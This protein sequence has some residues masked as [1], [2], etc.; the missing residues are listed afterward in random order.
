MVIRLAI[1]RVATCS[2]LQEAH[3]LL[4]PVRPLPEDLLLH[5]LSLLHSGSFFQLIAFSSFQRKSNLTW[6]SPTGAKWQQPGHSKQTSTALFLAKPT[7]YTTSKRNIQTLCCITAFPASVCVHS[8]EPHS[9]Q[10]SSRLSVLSPQVS[11]HWRVSSFSWA[12]YFAALSFSFP[13][14]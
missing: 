4:L 6:E 13:S 1:S 12:S 10:F 14:F 2:I 11:R 9:S 7:L 5:P 8:S 3:P